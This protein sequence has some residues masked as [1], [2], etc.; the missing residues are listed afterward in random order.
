M[1]KPNKGVVLVQLDEP[2]AMS[3]GGIAMLPST[4]MD[5]RRGAVKAVGEGCSVEVGETV[6]FPLAVGQEVEYDGQGYLA[7]LDEDLCGVCE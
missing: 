4:D 2:E 6:L 5:A 3:P 1:L 7:V